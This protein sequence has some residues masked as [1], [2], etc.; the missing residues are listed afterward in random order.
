MIRQYVEQALRMA[1]YVK[2]EDGTYY[3]EVAR[4]DKIPERLAL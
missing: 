2:L 4:L 1:R 3:G